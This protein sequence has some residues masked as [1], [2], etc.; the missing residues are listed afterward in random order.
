LPQ[1]MRTDANSAPIT[2]PK[3]IAD[4]MNNFFVNSGRAVIQNNPP[5][6]TDPLASVPDLSASHSMYA[7]PASRKEIS[8]IIDSL[9]NTSCGTDQIKAKVVKAIKNEILVPLTHLVN[10]SLKQGTFPDDLKKSVVTPI[11]KK[12]RKD[13]LNNYRPISVLNVFSKIMEKIMHC[14]LTSYL[15]AVQVLYPKQ[16]GFRKGHSTDQ[17]VTEAVSIITKALNQKRCVLAVCMDLSKAFDSID[18]VI[19]C[20]KLSRLGITGN[21]LDWFCSYLANRMQTTAFNGSISAPSTVKCGVPQGSILG[22]LLFILYINDLQHLCDTCEAVLYADD[23]NLFF[24]F[25]A[26]DPNVAAIVNAKLNCV[27]DWFSCNQLALNASKTNYIVFSGRRKIKIDGISVNGSLLAQKSE[28]NFLG[29]ILDQSLSWRPHIQAVSNKISKSIGV[30]RKINRH[31]SRKVMLSLYNSLVLPY[32]QY[33]I[34]IWGSARPTTLNSLFVAQ[35]KALKTALILPWRTSTSDLFNL[36]NAL[37]LECLYQLSVATFIFK[38]ENS[39]LPSCFHSYFQANNQTH[40]FN[41]RSASLFRLPLFSTSCCQQSI[42]FQGPKIW[43]KIPPHIRDCKTIT[44]FKAKLKCHLRD[45]WKSN[46]R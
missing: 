34:S 41:T 29:I 3:D 19:L 26:D 4:I 14:R 5:S 18:H 25:R 11:Y 39:L 1:A 13:D 36:T 7:Q 8:S 16:F 38:F 28:I 12:G 32:L 27:S 37:P 17:A 9:K 23:C 44:C 21:L 15:D 40:R 43:S 35:K 30:L 42:L 6:N 46:H 33:G 22:P 31:L 45:Q 24:D 20:K 2:N 10:L